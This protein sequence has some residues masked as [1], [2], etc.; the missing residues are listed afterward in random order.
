LASPGS[1][2]TAGYYCVRK[3]TLATQNICPTGS[4]CPA[5]TK[6]PIPCPAGTYNDLT[7]KATLSDCKAC[8]AGKF[9]GDS[10]MIAAPTSA[11]ADCAPG[12]E[13]TLGARTKYPLDGTTGKL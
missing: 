3:S 13:C 4:Y 9:C 11:A 6:A 1:D 12:Y 10:G 8:V 2:C 5:G 7:T